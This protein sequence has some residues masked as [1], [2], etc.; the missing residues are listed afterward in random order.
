MDVNGY[1]FQGANNSRKPRYLGSLIAHCQNINLPIICYTHN[2]SLQELKNIKS[3]YRL[4]NLEIKILELTDIKLHHK[5]N[6]IRKNNFNTDLDGRGPEIMWG[7]FDLLERELEGYDRVYWV[8]AGIQHP[9]IFRWGQ[10]K[11]YNKADD[12]KDSQKLNGWWNDKDVH[13]FPNFFN[14]KIFK[15]LDEICEN[16]IHFITSRT[17]QILYNIFNEKNIINT[18]I[19]LPYPIGGMFGGDTKILKKF[20]DNFWFLAEKIVNENVLV[21]EDCIMKPSFDMLNKNEK[22]EF[23][24]T[25]WSCGE[26]DKFHFEDWDESWGEPKP[27]YTV[28]NDILNYKNNE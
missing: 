9:G 16:K 12:H 26:H 7:K 3:E 11:K 25:S 19:N 15:K 8:D 4:N 13:N 23:L 14:N 22:V 27:F 18:P 1:P 17:P 24:F 21:Q 6:E 28:F 2:K 20:I 5:I 10:S